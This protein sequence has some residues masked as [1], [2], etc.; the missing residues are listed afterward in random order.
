MADCHCPKALRPRQSVF[1]NPRDGF[2]VFSG[3]LHHRDPS[4]KDALQ[5][6]KV[7]LITETFPP[8]INGVAMTLLQLVEGLTDRG[9]KLQVICPERS[10]RDEFLKQRRFE[11]EMVPGLPLPRYPGLRFGLPAHRE[12][13]RIWT[14]S[15]PDL[16]NIA[17]EGPLGWSAERI[18]NQLN[19][20]VITTFHT[21]FHSYMS[22]YGFGVMKKAIFW[23]LRTMRRRVKRTFVPS[24]ELKTELA[25]NGFRDLSILSRGVDTKLFNPTQ[26]D[27][28]LRRSWG[29][30]DE[31]PVVIYVG[32]LAAEKNLPLTLKAW[33]Q[34]QSIAPNIR[35]VIVGDGPEKSAIAEKHPDIIFAGT[36]RGESLARHYASADLFLFASTTETFGNVITEAM[37]S[38]L[39]VLCYDYAAGHSY[40]VDTQN[41]YTVPLG[42]EAA[43]LESAG[44]IARSRDLWPD[45]RERARITA[46]T[47]SWDAV[48]DGF[49]NE[50]EAYAHSPQ[51]TPIT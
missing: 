17:T 16:V 6:V 24:E 15:R 49:A 4:C 38:G 14:A 13:K 37:A 40:I 35:L 21:N 32:R 3:R 31:T 42:N 11:M 9:H 8:E 29:V 19:I 25:S 2:S 48:I 22:S 7:S 26:R 10:D 51:R 5:G 36:Q 41:G 30:D 23:W 28:E 33:K 45:I 43:F 50:I 44:N 27:T 20:P 46:E 34:M 47:I 12:I 1:L 18:A 39:V